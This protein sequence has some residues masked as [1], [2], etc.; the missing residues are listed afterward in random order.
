MGLRLNED[1][2]QAVD[3]QVMAGFFL[4]SSRPD[5][6]GR[7]LLLQ[8]LRQRDQVINV[9]SRDHHHEHDA[10]GGTNDAECTRCHARQSAKIDAALDELYADHHRRL[11]NLAANFRLVACLHFH[12]L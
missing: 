7:A 1:S 3:V 10:C 8:K 4:Y 2:V 11:D 12:R 9:D 5:H 6:H